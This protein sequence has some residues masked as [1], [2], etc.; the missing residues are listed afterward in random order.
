M[1]KLK[2]VDEYLKSSGRCPD[3]ECDQDALDY[4][5]TDFGADSASLRVTCQECGLEF[6]EEY[7]LN[8]ITVIKSE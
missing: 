6:F 5:G 1:S 3:K 4:G 8:K 2:S 7:I